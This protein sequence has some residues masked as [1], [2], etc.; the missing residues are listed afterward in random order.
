M[1]T[2]KQQ[3]GRS[4]DRAHAARQRR[5]PRIGTKLEVEQNQ[6]AAQPGISLK[7]DKYAKRKVIVQITRAR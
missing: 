6:K 7:H 4:E 5:K 1:P 2:V 3:R